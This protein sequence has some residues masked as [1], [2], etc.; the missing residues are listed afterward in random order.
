[1]Q[2]EK[3]N[4]AGDEQQDLNGRDDMFIS[5]DHFCK[6]FFVFILHR[7]GTEVKKILTKKE[8]ARGKARL[9]FSRS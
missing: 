4:K 7:F 5:G 2:K 9:G 6:S 3:K 8:K 1:M